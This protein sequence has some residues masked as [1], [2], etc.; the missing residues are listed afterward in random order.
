MINDC[1][2]SFRINE[3]NTTAGVLRKN[4]STKRKILIRIA[5][6]HQ[7]APLLERFSLWSKTN[8]ISWCV[9]RKRKP[10]AQWNVPTDKRRTGRQTSSP[11]LR[12]DRH[13][14]A[15]SR[16]MPFSQSDSIIFVH[17]TTREKETSLEI[18]QLNGS[19]YGQ[20]TYRAAIF[21]VA[22]VTKK[23]GLVLF[24]EWTSFWI[25]SS[26]CAFLFS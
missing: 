24:H 25:L 17:T 7:A 13:R 23:T 16:L 14:H 19:T 10:K 5:L 2:R 21:S 3:F 9:S 1:A 22:N 18:Q 8:K 11:V 20:K 6:L 12:S 4:S 26:N 15:R